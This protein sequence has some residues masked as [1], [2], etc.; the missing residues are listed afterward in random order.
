[1]VAL[2]FVTVVVCRESH[3]IPDCVGKI[4]IFLADG[5]EKEVQANI[6]QGPEEQTK[7][8]TTKRIS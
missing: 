7:T 1:M 4:V 6:R 2:L 3:C 8:A 5:Y